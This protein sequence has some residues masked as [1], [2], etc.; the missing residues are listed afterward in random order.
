[1]RNPSLGISQEELQRK[2]E[3]MR[4]GLDEQMALLEERAKE[5]R[6]QDLLEGAETKADEP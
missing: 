6:L 5:A 1:M 3:K 2:R 4:Q